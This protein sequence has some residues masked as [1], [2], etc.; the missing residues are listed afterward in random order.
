MPDYKIDTS[1]PWIPQRKDNTIHK[2]PQKTQI[3]QKNPKHD[4]QKN[5]T[6]NQPKDYASEFSN[7][8]SQVDKT[9]MKNFEP[10]ILDAQ[11]KPAIKGVKKAQKVTQDARVVITKNTDIKIDEKYQDTIFG[12]SP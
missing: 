7:F 5:L 6:Q 12:N 11:F 8:M 2:F 4:F 1:K 10:K 3:E 9:Y